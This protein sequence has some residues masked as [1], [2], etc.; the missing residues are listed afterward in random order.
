ME[1]P[2]QKLYR[3]TFLGIDADFKERYKKCLEL[4]K[5]PCVLYN[6]GSYCPGHFGHLELLETCG[7]FLMKNTDYLIIKSYLSPSNDSYITSKATKYGF[8][9]DIIPLEKRVEIL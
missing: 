7:E 6:T 2:S 3:D 4:G 5:K 9:D 1:E 8:L